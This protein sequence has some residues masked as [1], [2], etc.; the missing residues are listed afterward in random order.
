MGALSAVAALLAPAGRTLAYYPVGGAGCLPALA[1]GEPDAFRRAGWVRAAS[2]RQAD[3]LL[4]LG[5]IGPKLAPIAGRLYAQM[6]APRRALLVGDWFGAPY[7]R[8]R[9]PDD[10]AGQPRVP[11]CPVAPEAVVAAAA[12]L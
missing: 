1:A 12:G 11:G 2:P 8:E 4:V 5:P 10:L 9:L 3:L 6:P 7:A